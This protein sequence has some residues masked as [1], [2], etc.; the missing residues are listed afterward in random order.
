VIWTQTEERQP[1]AVQLPGQ[2]PHPPTKTLVIEQTNCLSNGALV[3]YLGAIGNPDTP[4]GPRWALIPDGVSTV[5]YTLANHDVFSVP[6]RGNLATAPSELTA[7]SNANLSRYRAALSSHL[8]TTVTESGPAQ[9]VVRTL[10][11]PSSLISDVIAELRFLERQLATGGESGSSSGSSLLG[12]TCSARTHRCVAATLNT[13]C[14][15]SQPCQMTRTIHRYR[16]VGAKPPPGTT[17]PQLIDPTAPIVA[18]TNRR[19]VSPGKL[20]LVLSG[21]PHRSVIVVQSS[22]CFSRSSAVSGDDG[23]LRAT[24]PSRSPIFLGGDR[25]GFLVCDVSA[26]VFARERGRVHVTVSRVRASQS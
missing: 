17:G 2:R 15:E 19:I 21:T 16:Y 13:T 7:P 14:D 11:R 24:V 6:V 8:P 3:G 1:T 12:A 23:P 22:A 25:R 4:S 10:A 5:T 20:E 9:T 26:L 18:R